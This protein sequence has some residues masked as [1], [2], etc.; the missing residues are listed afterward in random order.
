MSTIFNMDE[1]W[2]IA[3]AIDD[4]ETLFKFILTNKKVYNRC[5]HL[6]NKFRYL[7]EAFSYVKYD[8]EHMFYKYLDQKHLFCS[9][10]NDWQ[11][12]QFIRL[13]WNELST[14]SLLV[15]H[16]DKINI[17]TTH[18]TRLPD[19]KNYIELPFVS[20]NDMK[21]R[22]KIF[23][24][25]FIDQNVDTCYLKDL[26]IA[27]ISHRSNIKI[28]SGDKVV[29]LNEQQKQ[30]VF[31][32]LIQWPNTIVELTDHDNLTLLGHPHI[33]RFDYKQD[34]FKCKKTGDSIYW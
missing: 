2:S 31:K 13:T 15:T 21:F 30:S 8:G 17:A 29:Y 18:F 12:K 33:D 5:K 11:Q 22:I 24:R 26:D 25:T 4:V 34:Y 20:V 14:D 16:I 32:A 9:V 7:I 3:R 10:E 28:T 27:Y 19:R 6:L 1:L 23:N